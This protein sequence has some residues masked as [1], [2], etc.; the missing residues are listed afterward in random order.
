MRIDAARRAVVLTPATLALLGT[1]PGLT[2][3]TAMLLWHL[4]KVLPSGGANLSLTKLAEHLLLSRVH[5]TISM[6]QLLQTG[7]IVRGPK[8]G[9]LYHYA[10][11]PAYF[12]LL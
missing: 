4:V 7:L 9:L 3:A 12:T 11:N 1:P 5:V 8:A 6:Q 2:A 10:L